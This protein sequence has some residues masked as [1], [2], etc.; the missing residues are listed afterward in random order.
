MVYKRYIMEDVI[1]NCPKCGQGRKK[2]D[3]FGREVCYRCS[4]VRKTEDDYKKINVKKCLICNGIILT[5]RKKYCSQL[6]A[7]IGWKRKRD[8]YWMDKLQ[9]SN[10]SWKTNEFSFKGGKCN[11]GDI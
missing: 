3:F 9:N 10:D 4:Y 6:C 11:Y 7:D 8:G 2:I 5:E 1:I